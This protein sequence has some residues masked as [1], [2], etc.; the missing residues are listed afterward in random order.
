MKKILID[1]PGFLGDIIF[2]MA[3]AQKYQNDGYDVDFPVLD[4]YLNNNFEYYFPGINFIPMSDFKIY[5]KYHRVDFFEDDTYKYIPLR[6]SPESGHGNHMKYKYDMLGFDFNM[7]RDIKIKRNYE[8]EDKLIKLLNIENVEYNLINEFHQR[9]F[10]RRE[11]I[12][13]NGLPNI[14][15]SKLDG[16]SFFDWIGVIQNAS[17]IHSVGTSIIFLLDVID[18]KSND[19]NL[20]RRFDK[21]HSTYNFLLNKKYK[22]H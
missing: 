22:Y 4:E 20:Y 21:S 2:V 7:W 12:V 11:I 6:C 5:H 15:M 16:F 1:Q 18:L 13:N 19:L 9:N 14:F 8:N 10:T 17:T 3:I